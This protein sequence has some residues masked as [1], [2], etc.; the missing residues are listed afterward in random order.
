MGEKETKPKYFKVAGIT[1]KRPGSKKTGLDIIDQYAGHGSKFALQREPTNEF[2][3]NAIQVRQV[4]GNG[5]SVVLGYVPNNEHTNPPYIANTFAP[6]MDAGEE[7][8]VSFSRK[9]TNEKT[10]E[11]RGLQLRYETTMIPITKD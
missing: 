8:K 9:F 6:L 4:F 10:G 11:C 2:D 1:F 5:G 3:K 7:I